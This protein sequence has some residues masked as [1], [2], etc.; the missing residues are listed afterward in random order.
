[1]DLGLAGKV[2]LVTGAGQGVGRQVAR[3]LAAEGAKIIINDLDEQRATNVAREISEA[4]GVALPVAADITNKTLVEAMVAQGAA[5][6]GPVDILVN[7]AGIIRERR[8][9][10][11]GTPYFYESDPA[12]WEKIVNLNYFGC[13]NCS[14]AVLPAMLERRSGKI[15]SIISD[16]GRV[17]EARLAVYSGAKAAIFGFTKALAREVGPHSINVNVISLSAVSHE[18]PMADWLAESA[19]AETNETLKKVLRQY[20]IGQGLGRLTR[21]QD[22]ADAVAFLA[23]D[24]AAYITGQCLA[25]NGGF[26]MV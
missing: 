5:E 4:G 3:T 12:F 15:I 10:E 6:L 1:M 22:A 11:L 20:P 25:V 13:M 16:A 9:G 18:A 8:T 2:A 14:Y 21:P 17:G 26:A 19:T 23:S 24:R 7:N